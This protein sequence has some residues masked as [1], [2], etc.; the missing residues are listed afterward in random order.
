MAVL[1]QLEPKN[2]FHY[3]ETICSIPH[4]SGNVEQISNYLADFA[5]ERG[6]EYN[7]DE[8]FNVIIIKEASPGYEDAEP[9]ILQGHMD[10]VA[11][12]KPD[13]P[14]DMAREGLKVRT[15]GVKIYAEGTSL[16]GDDGIAVA[17]ALALLDAK[18]IA[19]PRL[20]VVITTEEETGMDGAIAVDLSGLQGK[21]LLNLDSEEE[22]V[23]MTSCAG[24]ST[25][26]C[27]LE[28]VCE[29]RKGIAWE[30]AVRGLQGGHSGAEIHKE[31]A[32]SN[33]VMG[34]L[35]YRLLEKVDCSIAS[36]EGGF[37]SNA[38]PRETRALFVMDQEAEKGFLAEVRALEAILQKE[39]VVKD[40]DIRLECV[41]QENGLYETLTADTF[42]R[43]A[44]MIY[45][46]PNGVQRMSA[47]IKGL[48]QTSLNLGILSWKDGVLTAVYALRSSVASEC[49]M[50]AEKLMLSC[51]MLGAKARVL[52]S[53][54]AWEYRQDSPL[55]DKMAAVFREMYKKEPRIEAI[56]AGMECGILAGKIEGLDC[57]SIGPDMQDIHTT[58]ETLSVASTQRVWEFLL[59][60]LKR[61]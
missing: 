52:N 11:V 9:V 39:Y 26:E 7:Q 5:R 59:E 18:D 37:A 51:R 55:R 60:V 13:C 12:K 36:L 53:Y 56:H 61:K 58:E 46:Q 50:L 20:E 1:E 57:V 16:G 19:H 44:A 17:Y 28:A 30:V 54:P 22:G 40:K 21:M 8:A 25:V 38:I 24:G 32:N 34:R 10:M 35:M 14:I 4:G 41:Q 42:V 48:V 29:Q 31:R 33:E 15:D 49:E 27:T 2:V 3:F 23:F 45:T 6:L 43:A 47:D